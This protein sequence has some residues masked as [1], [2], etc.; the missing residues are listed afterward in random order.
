MCN[1]LTLEYIHYFIVIVC[2]HNLESVDNE[3]NANDESVPKFPCK[4]DF[5][6]AND[7]IIPSSY[8][9]FVKDSNMPITT[10]SL[11]EP[12]IAL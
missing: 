5:A 8:P 11:K 12:V 1:V 2:K 6:K 10:A 3:K 7:A 9:P 4:C